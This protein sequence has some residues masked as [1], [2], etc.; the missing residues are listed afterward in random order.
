MEKGLQISLAP[1]TIGTLFG[2]PITS[3]LLTSWLVVA[4]L[5]VGAYCIGRSLKL[6]PGRGQTAV[7]T[8]V[9]TVFDYVKEAL[10]SESLAMRYFPLIMTIFLFI[11]FG[12]LLGLFPIMETVGIHTAEGFKGLFYPVNADLNIPLALAIISFCTIEISGVIYLGALKYGGK[13]VNLTSPMN[14][15]VGVLELIGDLAR[16]VSLSFRLFGNILA[17]HLL[18]IVI[19]FFIPYLAPLPFM[20]FEVFVGVLQAAIFALLTLFFIKLAIEEPHM[21]H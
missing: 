9:T 15:F 4:I 17:G 16:L 10:G 11:L 14:L 5:L 3:T 13:F 6:V 2:I 18:I 8:L 1:H 20:F 19:M 7:E 12:N 21:A